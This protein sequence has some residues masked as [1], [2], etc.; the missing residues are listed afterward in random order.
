VIKWVE[1]WVD[2][3]TGAA[4]WLNTLEERG[5]V[6]DVYVTP[7]EADVLVL[8][9]LDEEEEESGFDYYTIKASADNSVN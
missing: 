4:Q 3:R 2:I 8:V 7:I 5:E 1:K 6:L 9:R